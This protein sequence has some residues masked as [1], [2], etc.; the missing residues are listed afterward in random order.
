VS[1][2]IFGEKSK[3]RRMQKYCFTIYRKVIL[4]SKEFGPLILTGAN[5]SQPN[6]ELDDTQGARRACGSVSRNRCI[7]AISSP[8]PRR[9]SKKACVS[10]GEPQ[11]HNIRVGPSGS[12][13][14]H[15]RA[16]VF[17]NG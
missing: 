3:L 9:E 16:F 15:C 17:D 7:L 1:S 8:S 13:L 2:R 11:D 6:E 4:T 10:P 14:E 5:L 12:P